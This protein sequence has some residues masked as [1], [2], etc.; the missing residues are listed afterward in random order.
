MPPIHGA[1]GAAATTA[2]T[3]QNC[4]ATTS[5]RQT[6]KRAG[7]RPRSGDQ[8]RSALTFETLLD[9]CRGRFGSSDVPCPICGPTKQRPASRT[10]PVLR[11][12]LKDGFATFNCVRCG[13][14]G[15][16]H[17]K[18]ASSAKPP[19]AAPCPRQQ[20]RK[21]R[22]EYGMKLWHESQPIEETLA[23]KYLQSVRCIRGPLPPTLRFYASVK[24]PRSQ[25][26]LP[27]LIAAISGEDHRV[28]SVQITFLD[29][30]T[31]TKAAVDPARR[32]FGRMLDGAV[33]LGA[34]AGDTLALAEGIETALSF[35]E[36]T[37]IICWAVLGKARFAKVALP[38]HVRHLHLCADTDGVDV[39]EQAKR[40]YERRDL[41][42]TVHAPEA[43]NDF[44]D[45][46]I[47]RRRSAA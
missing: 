23:E 28:V 41:D 31:A 12:W 32:T 11:I 24:V 5:D 37:G 42:V 16:V 3:L 45:D 47:A 40:G 20:V 39:C 21:G 46:L 6:S 36:L 18:G 19:T 7:G 22:S 26:K 44:N 9:L 8:A 17:A 43:G 10:S 38:A 29:Q 15:Y 4:P 1:K 33:R 35:T 27:A 25:L 13:A 2:S 30:R 14:H 34:A